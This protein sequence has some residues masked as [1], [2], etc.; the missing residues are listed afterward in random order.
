[1]TYQLG[2]IQSIMEYV[3]ISGLE[4]EYD[5]EIIFFN[6]ALP[7]VTVRSWSVQ[8]GFFLDE[9]NWKM[10]SKSAPNAVETAFCPHNHS[11]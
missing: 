8:T 7:P 5:F 11:S 3:Y 10:C 1:M 9:I 6:C 2:Q 4:Q